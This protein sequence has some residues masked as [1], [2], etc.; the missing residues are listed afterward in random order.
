MIFRNPGISPRG[1]GGSCVRAAR[2]EWRPRA[3]GLRPGP[4]PQELPGR[5]FR[6]DRSPPARSRHG[7]GRAL[8][9]AVG[10]AFLRLGAFPVRR[11]EADAEAMQTARMLVE[12]L[13]VMFP[14]GTGCTILTHSA[15]PTT[16][17]A[18]WRSRPARRSSQRPSLA[19]TT[20]GWGR[21]PSHAVCSLR[22]RPR[23]TRRSSPV[24]TTRSTS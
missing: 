16:V 17:R 24:E 9:R 13:L 2:R 7:Q 3:P 6:G 1:S 23:S 14:E 11:G 4:E 18:A 12:G 20:C 15:P 19:R 8:Q 22:L 5:V 21:F 10:L